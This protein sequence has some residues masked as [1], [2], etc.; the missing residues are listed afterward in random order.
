[1]TTDFQDELLT[2]VDENNKVLGQIERGKAHTL[3]GVYY[4][5]IF[6]LVINEENKVSCLST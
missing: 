3:K 2:Q 1:M 4:R 6:V 5:T